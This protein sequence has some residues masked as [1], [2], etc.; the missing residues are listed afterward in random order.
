MTSLSSPITAEIAKSQSGWCELYDIY[1]KSAVT[2][3]GSIGSVSVLRF[4]TNPAG[5]NFFTPKL[6]PEPTG[7]QGNAQ[8]YTFWPFVREAAKG[9]SKFTADRMRITASNVTTE[10]SAM[11]AAIDWYDTTVI[12]RKVSLT[13][14]SPTADDCAVLWSGRV[15]A[16]EITEPAVGLECSS[17]LAG[18]QM[19][20]LPSENMH[21]NCRFHWAD[22]QCTALRYKTTNYKTGT[23]G[24]SSST[25]QINSSNFTEDTATSGSYGT[26]LVNPLADVAISASSDG[27]NLTNVAVTVTVN[28]SLP[29]VF[30]TASPHGLSK[31]D[32]IQFTATTFP[33]GI[34]GA[35]NYYVIP[36]G[37]TTFQV[38][39]TADGQA[40]RGNS[41]GSNVKVSTTQSFQ[42][43]AVKSGN[44]GYWKLGNASDWGT[45]T[46][47]FY[48]I[49]DAQAGVANGDLKPYIQFDFGS[50][51]SILL[52]RI[53][54]VEGV[55][56][57]ELPR[58]IQIH[59]SSSPTGPWTY[60]RP[61]EMPPLGGVLYEF[62]IDP[63]GATAHRY[64]RICV[65]SRW[66]QAVFYSLFGKCYAYLEGRH[67]WR[68][69]RITFASNTTTVALR[70]ISRLVRESYSGAIIVP[71]LPVA[72]ANGDTFTIERGCGRSF[73]DCGARQNTENFGGFLD[74]PY[75][76]V[77]R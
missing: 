67:Y 57:E 76:Q 18:L 56:L 44:V 73:N 35:T 49:P 2:G 59:S 17:D 32:V 34:S 6:A 11:V 64:W 45:L 48:Q 27:G 9:D 24:S 39:A 8:A 21:V 20:T 65:R 36:T 51:R 25:T 50:A 28:I 30:T 3:P 71:T 15:D 58:V 47:G 29:Y 7:T 62:N 75:Q 63:T 72:P 52:W 74:L 5:L 12:I 19:A 16:V 37:S 14:A 43:S 13:I 61:A 26:D 77:I 68:A 40:I 41:T 31:N 4:C 66:A 33:N 46:N 53:S 70:N 38:A 1:L 54:S 23:V 10:Y 69:G 22:D 55:R 60:R 42:A